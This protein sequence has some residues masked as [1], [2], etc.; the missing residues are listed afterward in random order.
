LD[1][2]SDDAEARRAITKVIKRSFA[3][4]IEAISMTPQIYGRLINVCAALG[5][6]AALLYSHA[7][8]FKW[9]P[10]IV[11]VLSGLGAAITYFRFHW[12]RSAVPEDADNG[13]HSVVGQKQSS[14]KPGPFSQRYRAG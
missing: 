13:G 8:E 10:L 9:I 12:L 6:L 4:T 7:G 2:S 5:V 14:S 11:A 3:E 1:W